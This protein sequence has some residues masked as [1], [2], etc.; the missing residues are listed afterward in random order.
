MR[1]NDLARLPI[2]GI[3]LNAAWIK[4]IRGVNQGGVD[5]SPTTLRRNMRSILPW[6]RRAPGRSTA[7]AGPHDARPSVPHDPTPPLGTPLGHEAISH[8]LHPPQKQSTRYNRCPTCSSPPTLCTW[9]G[10]AGPAY[11]C[12]LGHSYRVDQVSNFPQPKSQEPRDTIPPGASMTSDIF[13]HMPSESWR[14]FA[15]EDRGGLPEFPLDPRLLDGFEPHYTLPLFARKP[16][17]LLYGPGNFPLEVR[18][19]D[20]SRMATIWAGRDYAVTAAKYR[21]AKGHAFWVD[22][23]QLRA[24]ESAS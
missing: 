11:I 20:C 4:A 15:T 21:C 23:K 18:C 2:I 7:D 3:M 9:I 24:V 1:I 13:S 12:E 8:P 14:L 10:E 5:K 17:P 6:L 19:R 22:G 16:K